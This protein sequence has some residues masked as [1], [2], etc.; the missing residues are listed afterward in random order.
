MGG[1]W[2]VGRVAT[3][4]LSAVAGCTAAAAVVAAPSAEA[5][6]Y[7]EG[8]PDS[9]F[10][11]DNSEHTYCWGANFTNSTGRTNASGAMGWLD[12]RSSPMYDTYMQPC[13][14][15]TDVRWI[16]DTDGAGDGEYLCE[17]LSGDTCYRATAAI[18]YAGMSSSNDWK[19]TSCHELGHSVGLTHFS[20][21]CM[22]TDPDN[23]DWSNHHIYD[24]VDQNF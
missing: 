20:A 7:A 24:H 17:D 13:S 16:Q 2:R 23:L 11:P 9:G 19:Q 8:Y 6:D 12:T 21:D 4:G 18:R 10:R 5:D 14:S 22:G 1:L 15:N 3:A